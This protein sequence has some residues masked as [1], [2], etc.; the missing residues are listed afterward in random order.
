MQK[1]VV[2]A[3]SRNFN[4]Y[5]LFCRTVDTYLSRIK[6][7]YDLI[8]LS[9][10]CRGTDMMAEQY[11]KDRG[12]K[13]EIFPADWSLGKKAGPL[14]NKAMI[15]VADYAIAFSSGGSGTCSL[16]NCA[17]KKGIPIKIYSVKT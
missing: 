4:N 15:D 8:I 10:H 13:L 2:I 12:L 17:K 5:E 9:G 11:A 1:R 16:I 7:D 6:N 3:G 14:R